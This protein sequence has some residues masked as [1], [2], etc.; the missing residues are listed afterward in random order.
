M[1]NQV[2]KEIKTLKDLK[3]GNERLIAVKTDGRH[4]KL[5]EVS[6]SGNWVM[7]PARDVDTVVIYHRHNGVNSIIVGEHLDTIPS[8][9]KG[10][11][12]LRFSG[13]KEVGHTRANWFEFAETGSRPVRFV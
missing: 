12:V 8:I 6:E 5:G 13:A 11:Y 7:N 3:R 10:R 4:L 2:V 9:A 1:R